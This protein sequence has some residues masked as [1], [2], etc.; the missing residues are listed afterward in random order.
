MPKEMSKE[1][2]RFFLPTALSKIWKWKFQIVIPA[3]T[4]MGFID[5]SGLSQRPHRCRTWAPRGKPRSSSILQRP[6]SWPLGT[7]AELAEQFPDMPAMIMNTEL[8][9]N[10]IG[11]TLGQVHSGVSYPSFS[12]PFQ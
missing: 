4:E 9:L 10:Q 5:E 2:D 3:A 12:G 8:P 7:P 1:D 11:E 6:A